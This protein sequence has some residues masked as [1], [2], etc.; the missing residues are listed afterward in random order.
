M[1]QI[2]S[3]RTRGRLHHTGFARRGPWP[4]ECFLEAS[5]RN[6]KIGASECRSARRRG[7]NVAGLDRYA[8]KSEP[9]VRAE[10]LAANLA[11]MQSLAGEV[12]AFNIMSGGG[13]SLAIELALKFNAWRKENF[14]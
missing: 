12:A 4:F 6:A 8:G 2:A 7:G 13:P 3:A 14:K 1:R 11:L 5:A 9:E 10:S